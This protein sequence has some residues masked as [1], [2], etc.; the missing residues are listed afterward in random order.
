[1]NK[2]IFLDRDGVINKERKNYVKTINEL[3]LFPVGEIIQKFKSNDFL[4]IVITNQSA[5]NRG[6]TTHKNISEIHSKIQNYLKSFNTSIDSYY[7]CPHTPDENCSCRKPKSGLI[8]QAAAD[9]NI[10]L[11]SSWMIGD[12]DSDVI[13]GQ[14]V[15][16]KTI[17]IGFNQTLKDTYDLVFKTR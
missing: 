10:D 1:M 7:Y 12:N 6:L 3:E 14:S 17:K 16:C 9:F 5:V 15:G 2:A 8:L 11:R 13:A 4:V